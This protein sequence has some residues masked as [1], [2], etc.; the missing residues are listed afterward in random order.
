M[1][2]KAPKKKLVKLMFHKKMI[3]PIPEEFNY[4]SCCEF[5][6]IDT[7]EKNRIMQDLK[8]LVRS[9][10]NEVDS[11]SFIHNFNFSV[12]QRATRQIEQFKTHG[13]RTEAEKFKVFN[14]LMSLFDTYGAHC[15]L[16]CDGRNTLIKKLKTNLNGLYKAS[17]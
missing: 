16:F 9:F 1:D 17:F 10:K 15:D 11:Q 3:Q 6:V 12:P 4:L 13:F 14:R 8:F 7:L 2:R 5:L